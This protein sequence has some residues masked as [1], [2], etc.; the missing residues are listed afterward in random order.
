MLALMADYE[1]NLG[2]DAIRNYAA[3]WDSFDADVYSKANYAAVLPEDAEI[4]RFASNFLVEAFRRR[5]RVGRAVDVGSGPNLYP[6]LLMLPWAERIVFTEFAINNIGWLNENL[7][8]SPG[9]WAWQPFW[10][11]LMQLREYQLVPDPQ[12]RLADSHEVIRLSVFDLPRRTWDMGSMFFVADGISSDEAEFGSAVRSFL[13]ALT[14]AAP[15]MM[16][17]MEG[18]TGYEVNGVEFPAVKVNFDSLNALLADL[19]VSGTSI[20]RTDK[21][22]RPLRHGYDAMLLVTGYV[23]DTP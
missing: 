13:G 5:P 3:P 23:E 19:P 20:L 21:T 2:D 22:A 9:E 12:R 14:P 15:F 4:I 7:A 8:V 11:L 1:P 6:A 17:F 10:D 16:A 18:S